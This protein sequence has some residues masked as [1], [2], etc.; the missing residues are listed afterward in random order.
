MSTVEAP[1]SHLPLPMQNILSR[2]AANSTEAE[3]A[4]VRKAY[5]YAA[6]AHAGQ[7]RLSG[8]PYL[9]H[10]LAVAEVLAELGFDAHS[11]AA[12][13]LHDT[14]EDTKV[15]LEE[16]DAEFGEQVADIVDGVTKISMMTFDSKE[17]QQAENIRKMILAMSHDIRVPI[18]KLADRVHNMRTLDFQKAH[19]RQRIAQRPVASRTT[20]SAK[21]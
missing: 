18:V 15:T 14:V 21:R 8:E 6:A 2:L 13:L 11:V 5:A 9:S 3:Q 12:G 19:K 17:E 10:P 1:A 16:V 7:V 4:L 20:R